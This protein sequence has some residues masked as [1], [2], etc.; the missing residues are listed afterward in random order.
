MVDVKTLLRSSKGN[1]LGLLFFLNKSGC[2]NHGF[3]MFA[4]NIVNNLAI[5][6]TLL[7]PPPPVYP[8]AACR[9]AVAISV[10][11]VLSACKSITNEVEGG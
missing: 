3:A 7:L 4:Q 2:F 1:L 10:Q 8:S 9:C 5:L 11:K 6:K